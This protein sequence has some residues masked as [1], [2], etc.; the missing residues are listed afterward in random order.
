MRYE[1]GRSLIEIVGVIAIGAVMTAAAIGMYRT[2]RD[3]HVR[4][5]ADAQLKQVAN[6]VK[7]LLQPRGDYSGVSVDYLIKAGALKSDKSP[8]GGNDWSVVA[9]SDGL[10]FSINLTQLS[11][12]EC[13]YFLTAVPTWATSVLINGYEVANGLGSCFST[14]TNQVSFIVE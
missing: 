1:S 6:D 8:L 2:M 14:P 4:N 5:V 9:S 12:G 10:S 11:Q 7:I 3:N 13:A